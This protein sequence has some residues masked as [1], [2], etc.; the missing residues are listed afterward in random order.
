MTRTSLR[1]K[2]YS[3]LL[4]LVAVACLALSLS[5]FNFTQKSMH[6]QQQA[7]IANV[8]KQLDGELQN[9]FTIAEADLRMVSN[10]PELKDLLSG[11]SYRK[12]LKQQ[13]AVDSFFLN[14]M[15]SKPSTKE[16]FVF[17]TRN[18]IVL[19]YS[20]NP[21]YE[22]SSDEAWI[23][24]T[25]GSYQERAKEQVHRV[26]VEAEEGKRIPFYMNVKSSEGNVI[27]AILITHNLDILDTISENLNESGYEKVI[28]T[29]QSYNALSEVGSF[30]ATLFAE[31]T[32]QIESDENRPLNGDNES[33]AWQGHDFSLGKAFVMIS[34]E[35]YKKSI[36]SLNEST[37][38]LSVLFTLIASLFVFFVI[39]RYMIKPLKI[40]VDMVRSMSDGSYIAGS[41][42]PRNDEFG[43]LY[44]EVENKHLTIARGNER[45]HTLAMY[46][47]MTGLFNKQYFVEQAKGRN[48]V[49]FNENLSFWVVNI[50]NFKQINDIHG[51]DVGDAVLKEIAFRLTEIKNSFS[52]RHTI[53][54]DNFIVGRATADEF[55]LM[56]DFPQN[57]SSLT[58]KISD[59]LRE[60]IQKSIFVE[61]REFNLECFI[62]W[63]Q[64]EHRTGFE[65]F[66]HAEMAMHEAK[67][68]EVPTLR[69]EKELIDRIRRNKELS[70]DIMKAL[71]LDLFTLFY[72]PKC[73]PTERHTAREFEALIRWF[74]EDGT[75]VSP[76]LF[77][78]F[79]EDASLIDLIDLWVCERVVK[80]IAKF[81]RDGW[82]NF[83]ISFNMSA[84]H[85][86]DASFKDKLKE[87]IID[88]NID[89]SH[90]Q[91]EIT[92]HSL[93]DQKNETISV[94]DAVRNLGVSVALD[95]FGTGHSSLEYIK[96][97]PINTLK[98]DRCFISDVHLDIKKQELLRHIIS[99][100]QSLK[101]QVVAEGVE[102]EKELNII[103]DFNCDLVQ[104]FLFYKPMP[105]TDILSM[106]DNDGKRK[107]IDI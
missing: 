44:E 101:L 12:S 58:S 97:L 104:G 87:W 19:S 80:D 10:L 32:N 81:E 6:Q 8:A 48:E 102:S 35:N 9:Y 20:E 30:D 74:K 34:E 54:D 95:D 68:R 47:D 64:G 78:P 17:N 67:Q 83:T 91:I 75:F 100:G 60:R 14:L 31:I 36:K 86:S 57:S 45:L 61:D 107:C 93:I 90:L 38:S 89:P 55:I 72:Q 82:S 23:S 99:M 49:V 2:L 4:P 103:R 85:L 33:W 41:F 66:Q 70:D 98:I 96:D 62:G 59:M 27:G 71:D 77:I 1:T 11:T 94:I 22:T 42:E 56:V 15:H 52:K 24:Q 50:V 28:F 5:F 92:E 37:V 16:L 76:G 40:A 18:E 43:I 3:L 7:Y 88:Y 39:N 65:L 84:K 29:D 25:H 26:V 73:A 69:F 53:S 63:D 105:I 79:A 13:D 46:D 106:F 21:F 51:Y